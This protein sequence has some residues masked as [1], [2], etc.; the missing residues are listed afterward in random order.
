MKICIITGKFRPQLCGVGDYTFFL[1]KAIK[2]IKDEVYIIT[3][4]DKDEPYTQIDDG[5]NILRIV[6][7][8]NFG[9]FLRIMKFILSNRITILNIQI[10][11]FAYSKRGINLWIYLMPLFLRL[12][13]STKIVSTVHEPFIPFYLS[14]KLILLSIFQR[15]TIFFACNFSHRVVVV[16]ERWR[17]VLKRAG[18]FKK[19][20]FIPVGANI[21]YREFSNEEKLKIRK[22]LGAN[23]NSYI[24]G[25]FGTLHVS[26]N[27]QWILDA[28][29]NLNEKG[30]EYRFI[31]IGGNLKD[32]KIGQLK[33][34]INTF[35]LDDKIIFTGYLESEE[36]QRFLS[37]VDIFIAPYID[38]VSGRRT[39]VITAMQY[40]LPIVTTKSEFTER[41]FLDGVNIKLVDK[42]ADSY[43]FSQNIQ[44]LLIDIELRHKISEGAVRTYREKFCWDI[45]A[46]KFS[47]IF[48]DLLRRKTL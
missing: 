1:A 18:V 30:F 33:K 35:G 25:S 31:W 37:I 34:E 27:F 17:N 7:H 16:A 40:G 41:I 4:T 10:S 2:R 21:P 42:D 47:I 11:H 8:W 13:S 48:E 24:I 44:L 3:T 26:K 32:E 45:I 14:F 12:F 46:E 39:T 15:I 22:T 36:I 43:N 20:E 6:K 5:V 29:K 23:E 28:L 9:A 19:I 38:G